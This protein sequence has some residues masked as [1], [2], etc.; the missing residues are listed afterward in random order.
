[1]MAYS[2][3]VSIT[4]PMILH[5]LHPVKNL[6]VLHFLVLPIKINKITMRLRALMDHQPI[7]AVVLR[8]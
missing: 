4:H 8:M 6:E 5:V 1:M 2:D 3:N 7:I